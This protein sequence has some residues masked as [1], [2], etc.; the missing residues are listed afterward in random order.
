MHARGDVA[1]PPLPIGGEESS[2]TRR[3]DV[4]QWSPCRH[5][6]ETIARCIVERATRDAKH[7]DVPLSVCR[8][9][10]KRPA[11][12]RWGSRWQT[13]RNVVHQL[14]TTPHIHNTGHV[15]RIMPWH[16]SMRVR[17]TA[18]LSADDGMVDER[19]GTVMN[20]ELCESDAADVP[21]HFARVQLDYMP[22]GVWVL[23]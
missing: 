14:L 17:L 11:H 4:R 21:A 2:A 20:I 18:K 6:W 5:C 10:D 19:T 13:D 8:D 3:R 7:L 1:T 9:C 16:K 15:H 23:C 22:N 12:Q